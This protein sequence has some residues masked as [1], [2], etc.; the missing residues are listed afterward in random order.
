MKLN[1]SY[2]KLFLLLLT[3][4]TY[5]GCKEASTQ[6]PIAQLPSDYLPNA[7]GSYFY[8][9]V[10]ATD[11]SGTVQSGTRKS[12]YTG[13]TIISST[14][15]Q[16]KVDTFQLNT[17]TSITKSYLRKTSS[18]VFGFIDTTGLVGSVPD[19]I[20][21]LLSFDLEYRL[22]YLPLSVGQTWP[23]YKVT[24]RILFTQIDV[25]SLN[26]EIVSKETLD[27]SFRNTT[28]RKDVYK[29]KYNLNVITGLTEPALTFQTYGWIAA[30][31]GFIKW[32][33]NSEIINLF[34]YGNV[35]LPGTI[36]L[37]ELSAYKIQ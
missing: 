8:Y 29:I 27:L 11:S 18:G 2:L 6:P 4:I 22:L 17:G 35:Y 34:S 20:L 25:V 37:E 13:D 23:V 3:V 28:I 19:S 9:N 31:I 7:D 24:A 10:S 14:S 16:I 36:V 21:S 30:D 12:Y 32:E 5:Y 33:G 26:A 15:Y 1:S